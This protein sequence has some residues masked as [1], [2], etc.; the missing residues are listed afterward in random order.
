MCK[1]TYEQI[2]EF[3]RKG[4]KIRC[5]ASVHVTKD[6]YIDFESC[7][8]IDDFIKTLKESKENLKDTFWMIHHCSYK[9]VMHNIANMNCVMPTHVCPHKHH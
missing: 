6:D 1:P 8:D 5:L 4:E 7:K 3:I 9:Y 2:N